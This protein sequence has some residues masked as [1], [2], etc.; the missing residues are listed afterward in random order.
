[1]ART[2]NNQHRLPPSAEF[3]HEKNLARVRRLKKSGAAD[4]KRCSCVHCESKLT[5]AVSSTPVPRKDRPQWF[6]VRFRCQAC[7]GQWVETYAPAGAQA[8]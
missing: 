8:G 7:G 6:E 2:K 1:M 4:E 5:V 3:T